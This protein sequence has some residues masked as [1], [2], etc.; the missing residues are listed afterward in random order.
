MQSEEVSMSEEST[1]LGELCF[2]NWIGAGDPT[3]EDEEIDLLGVDSA[4]R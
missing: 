1:E 4:K 2:D 3:T